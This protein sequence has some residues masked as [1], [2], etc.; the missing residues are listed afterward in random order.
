MV[1]IVR[2][3]KSRYSKK[4]LD[5]RNDLV[6]KTIFGEERNK[7]L[8]LM[9]LNA[10]LTEEVEEI[11]FLDTHIGAEFVDEKYSVMDIRVRAADQVEINIEMQ[12]ESHDGFEQRMLLYWAKLYTKQL[13]GGAPYT[14]LKKA[15]QISIADFKFLKNDHFHSMFH[16]I[17]KEKR[18]TFTDHCEIHVLELPKVTLGKDLDGQGTLKKWMLFLAGDD[19]T[20]EAL[21]MSDRG[22]GKAYNELQR[23]SEDEIMRERAMARD[24]FLSDQATRKEL[25]ELKGRNEGKNEGRNEAILAMYNNG[26]MPAEKIAAIMELTVE[27]VKAVINQMH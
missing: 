26:G 7:G 12:V 9:L 13:K 6:F 1:A 18:F 24:K 19:K 21:A 27:E 17:E 8:L 22:I 25:A 2:E 10:I 3:E 14:Q 16:L 4:L 11:I 23:V 15:V 5:V 20:K